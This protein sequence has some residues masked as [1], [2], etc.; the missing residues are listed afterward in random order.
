M[1]LYDL[2]TDVK[3][4]IKTSELIGKYNQMLL[5]HSNMEDK[6]NYNP[7]RCNNIREKLKE[8]YDKLQ[9]LENIYFK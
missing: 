3:S 8:L 5:Y 9:E 1:N 4:M 2:A 6:A 7:E